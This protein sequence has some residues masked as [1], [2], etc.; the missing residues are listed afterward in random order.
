M[1][2]VIQVYGTGHMG[3]LFT[4]TEDDEKGVLLHDIYGEGNGTRLQYSCLENPTDR[5]AW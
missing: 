3:M 1:A 5:G 4:E 2:P